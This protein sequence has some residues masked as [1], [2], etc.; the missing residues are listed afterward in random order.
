MN[1]AEQGVI[2]DGVQD[3]G[4]F[5]AALG[6]YGLQG[7][8][9]ACIGQLDAADIPEAARASAGASHA[10]LVELPDLRLE[11]RAD[12]SRHACKHARAIEGMNV[13]HDLIIPLS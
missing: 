1:S 13:G 5:I 4:N 12:V 3:V 6:K 10:K 2:L 8:L 11:L 7:C 9:Q